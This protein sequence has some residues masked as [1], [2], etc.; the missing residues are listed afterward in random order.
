MAVD[1][2]RGCG[3][4]PGR[5]RQSVAGIE[6]DEN[7]AMPDGTVAFDLGFKPAQEA[8]GKFQ[9]AEDTV[10]GDQGTSRSRGWRCEQDILEVVAAGRQDRS[11][12]IDVGGI[13]QVEDG[14]MLHGEDLIHALDAE[15]AFAV[16][17]VGDVGLLESG[18]L[19][20]MEAGEFAGIDTLQKDFAEVVLQDFELHWG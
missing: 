9:N 15:A 3:I 14:K 17:E 16:E 6:S 2:Q 8:S 1:K 10:G 11:A 7:E 19:R 12:P 20:E 18:L 5:H 13:E 4:Q